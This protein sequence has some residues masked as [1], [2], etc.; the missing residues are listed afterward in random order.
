MSWITWVIVGVTWIAI[1]VSTFRAR[2]L[3]HRLDLFDPPPTKRPRRWRAQT[4]LPN[5]WGPPLRDTGVE[6]SP[7]TIAPA[8]ADVLDFI[9]HADDAGWFITS[10]MLRWTRQTATARVVEIMAGWIRPAER[11][12]SIEPAAGPVPTDGPQPRRRGLDDRLGR[13]VKKST[14]EMPPMTPA[15]S[16]PAGGVASSEDGATDAV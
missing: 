11:S 12:T 5:P 14:L 15:G 3:S 7:F 6:P 2:R 9:D 10:D 13:R 16:D 1:L 8:P 4:P